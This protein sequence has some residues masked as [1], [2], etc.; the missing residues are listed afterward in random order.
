MSLIALEDLKNIGIK[1]ILYAD[2]GLFYSDEP[3][4]FLVE[5]QKILDKYGIGAYF[6]Q[7]K[8]KSV[9]EDGKWISKLKLVGLIYDP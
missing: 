6:N 7:R 1:H 8:C 3:K 5:A 4:D 9:K 2:D